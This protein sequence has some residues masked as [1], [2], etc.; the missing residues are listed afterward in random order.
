MNQDWLNEIRERTKKIPLVSGRS[1]K[2]NRISFDDLVFVPSQLAKKPVDYFKEKIN[3]K[4]IVGKK[5]KRPVEI[6][7]PIVIGAMSFGALSREAKTALAKASAIADTFENTGE[8]GMLAEER[9]Y[10]KHLIVQYSTGRFGINDEI[11]KQAD[12]VEIKIGQGAKGG[13]GGLLPKEKI[14][15]EIAKVRAVEKDKDI[16]SPASH[17]DIKNIDD[18]R[19]KN[20]LD[21]GNNRGRAHYS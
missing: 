2:L 4:T 21:K 8:G 18:L 17:L 14:T 16:Y 15:D 10:S 9:K 3:S 1:N 11:L 19:K 6:S 20:W 12:A 5:S 7:I 13:Q